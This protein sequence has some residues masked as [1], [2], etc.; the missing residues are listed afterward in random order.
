MIPS[1]ACWIFASGRSWGVRFEHPSQAA[2]E[3]KDVLNITYVVF[4]RLISK[5]NDSLFQVPSTLY[6]NTVKHVCTTCK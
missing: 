3:K 5:N 1:F 2:V 4:S 6:Y